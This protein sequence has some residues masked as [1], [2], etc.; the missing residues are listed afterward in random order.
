MWEWPDLVNSSGEMS[1]G[2][3]IKTGSFLAHI[4]QVMEAKKS[5]EEKEREFAQ[6]ASEEKRLR[7]MDEQFRHLQNQHF[8]KVGQ[9]S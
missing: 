4:A 1:G 2:A 3:A 9:V 8:S 5:L 7:N 6:I